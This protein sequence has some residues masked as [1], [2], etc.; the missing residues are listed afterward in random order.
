ML[1]R[2]KRH[3]WR[4]AGGACIAAG[5][6]FFFKG[7]QIDSQWDEQIAATEGRW[8]EIDRQLLEKVDA[9][10]KARTGFE[11]SRIEGEIISLQTDNYTLQRDALRKTQELYYER[12]NY[13]DLYV[14][15]T[16]SG[17]LV[18]ALGQARDARR[19][20][21]KCQALWEARRRELEACGD[22]PPPRE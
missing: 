15:L 13:S 22:A 3:W 7:R 18:L 21:R 4:F 6:W 14:I 2:V 9:H 19:W 5:L 17:F 12:Y 10:R 20:K 8:K 11:E 1:G 16:A